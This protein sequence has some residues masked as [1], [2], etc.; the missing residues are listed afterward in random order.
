MKGGW[1]VGNFLPTA[2]WTDKFEVCYK[3]HKKDEFWD[4]HYHVIAT[5]I[6][7]LISGSMLINDKE[8]K[9]GQIFVIEPNFIAKPTFLEDCN[10]VVIKTPSITNDKF[11]VK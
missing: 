3:E 8:I 6:N 10:L 9:A 1:F 7:F 4:E 11:I 5:E 2:Y